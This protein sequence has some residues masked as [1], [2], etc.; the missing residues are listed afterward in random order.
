M[1]DKGYFKWENWDKKSELLL[2]DFI[3]SVEDYADVVCIIAEWTEEGILH[4]TTFV[5]CFDEN[6]DR[7]YR[8]EYDVMSR[9][10]G[11][12]HELTGHKEGVPVD[13]TL[14]V[15]PDNVKN[16]TP[17]HGTVIIWY[18]GIPGIPEKELN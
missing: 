18:R 14:R 11:N 17:H 4:V 6:E 9:H 5:D 16:I 1:T 13:W 15:A 7:I 8:A 2:E 10:N 3:T 12:P